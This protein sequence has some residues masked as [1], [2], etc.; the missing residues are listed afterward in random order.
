MS[1]AAAFLSC[2]RD[3]EPG[4][5]PIDGECRRTV[6]MYTVANNSLH[7]L[8]DNNIQQALAAVGNGLP[9]GSRLLVYL[10][11]WR[12]G[13]DYARVDSTVLIELVPAGKGR[14]EARI[15]KSYGSQNSL[16]PAVM[17]A[18]LNDV[19]NLAPN[20]GYGMVLS[21]HATGWFPPQ[22]GYIG[23]P[24][25]AGT[26]PA[27]TGHDWRKAP[28]AAPTRTFGDDGGYSMS[29]PDLVQGLSAVRFDFLLFD[30]CFMSSVEALYELRSSADY[31]VASPTEVMGAGF[32][33]RKIL[34]YLFG[35]ETALEQTCRIFMDTYRAE[36]TYKS[37]AV[38]LVDCR[39][40]DALAESV[41][42]V[43]HAP[44]NEVNPDDVQALEGMGGG[45]SNIHAFFDLEDYIVQLCPDE[46][47]KARFG[48]ALKAAVVF[49]DHTPQIYSAY[50]PGFFDANRLCGIST[51]IPRDEFPGYK[52]LWKQTAWGSYV[53]PAYF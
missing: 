33:Y 13:S 39:G 40:L 8:L 15:L 50:I 28:G 7:Q 36:P 14:A 31:I 44:V 43:M 20:R 42:A 30:A 22:A 29:V 35:S 51:Y 23:R 3:E 16:D 48:A 21:S 52:S 19:A 6:V 53:S 17:Q 27:L 37:A 12:Y 25:G 2:S 9:E 45:G 5:G 34:P 38:T 47:L 4:P 24:F 10:D 1:V 46:M 32:P 26:E 41:R 11:T 18:V 49:A